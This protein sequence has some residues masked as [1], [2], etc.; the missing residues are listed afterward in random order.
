MERCHHSPRLHVCPVGPVSRLTSVAPSSRQLPPRVDL[1]SRH[2]GT[3]VV[4]TPSA[5]GQPQRQADLH[6]PGQPSPV[7]PGSSMA[8]VATGPVPKL[9]RVTP[10]FRPAPVPGRH[11]LSQTPQGTPDVWTMFQ[12]ACP[13]TS[14][15]NQP[16]RH[17]LRPGPTPRPQASLA[18]YLSAG[19]APA[20]QAPGQNLHSLGLSLQRTQRL[21]L[22]QQTQNPGLAW[23]KAHFS[24]RSTLGDLGQACLLQ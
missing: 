7:D 24:A 17:R 23:S 4:P 10:D 3:R 12:Q 13:E 2:P 19:P 1:A 21:G 9:A 22:S 14:A 18:D 5:S 11:P 8:S 20:G 16:H 15:L 6:S